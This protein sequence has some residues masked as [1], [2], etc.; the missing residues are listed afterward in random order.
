LERSGRPRLY[1]EKTWPMRLPAGFCG[2]KA[3]PA[4]T[5]RPDDDMTAAIL[6][7]RDIAHAI[8]GSPL[9]LIAVEDKVIDIGQLLPLR[10]AVTCLNQHYEHMRLRVVTGSKE[11]LARVDWNQVFGALSNSECLQIRDNLLLEPSYQRLA[12]L[13]ALSVLKALWPSRPVAVLL[14]GAGRLGL[15]LCKQII[16]LGGRVIVTG[17]RASLGVGQSPEHPQ[18]AFVHNQWA[19]LLRGDLVTYVPH[20]IGRLASTSDL[21]RTLAD[22]DVKRADAIVALASAAAQP[23]IR[24]EPESVTGADLIEQNGPKGAAFSEIQD[25]ARSLQVP[26]VI[27]ASSNASRLGGAGML[28]YGVANAALDA[29]CLKSNRACSINFDAF[30]DRLEFFLLADLCPIG[31]FHELHG[32]PTTSPHP[33]CFVC[34]VN[35]ET[36]PSRTDFSTALEVSRSDTFILIG[37]LSFV[38]IVLQRR[39]R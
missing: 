23:S 31:S 15:A 33:F 17:R 36:Y 38:L 29:L 35:T 20:A 30:P 34:S 11:D 13:P 22:L 28:P 21:L 24:R 7:V 16:S 8:Q 37:R 2:Q 19:D 4:L 18:A 27:Y 25:L 14:G 5:I 6:A 3:Q 32:R 10:T 39:S 1:E 12:P 26:R 9:R